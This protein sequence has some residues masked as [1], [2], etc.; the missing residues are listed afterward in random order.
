[1]KSIEIPCSVVSL[2]KES[3]CWCRSLESIVF[4]CG[5][6]LEHIE[7][8]ALSFETTQV[9]AHGYNGS[10]RSI[11]IPA[12]AVVL[13]KMSFSQRQALESVLSE[14]GSRLERIEECA[15][16]GSGLRSIIIPSSVVVLGKRSF[17]ECRSLESVIF[18][19]GSRLE[20]IEECAFKKSGLK[21][22]EIP[23]SVVVLANWSFHQCESLY[24]VVFENGSRLERL[25][26]F[27]F[28]G[29]GLKSI[30]IPPP[31]GFLGLPRFRSYM[32][33]STDVKR[34]EAR[35]KT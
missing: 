31:V 4:E 29:S 6:R 1:L 34:P 33:G 2:G 20:C 35:T 32:Y 14:S 17:L 10:L 21:M 11:A 13:G 30:E 5:S 18:E 23:C 12:A 27:A 26:P 15:F 8:S 3:F 19:S 28:E 9:L 24:S 25:E 22:I 16:H 7:E